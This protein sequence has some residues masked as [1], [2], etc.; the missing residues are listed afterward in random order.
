MGSQV[1]IEALPHEV[2]LSEKRLGRLDGLVRRYVDSGKLPGAS[3][4]VVRNSLVAHVFNYGM[5]DVANGVAMS[6][7]TIVRLYSMTKPITSVAAMM[8]HEEGAFDLLDP[9]SNFIPSFADTRVWAGGNRQEPVT[10][11][12][13][14]PMRIWNLLS[15]TSGLTYGF[16]LDH[17][18]DA[19]YRRAG[20]GLSAPEG[21]DLA[22]ACDFFAGLPLLFEPGTEWNYSVSTD[23]LGRV[24][25]VASG[26]SLD[27]FFEERIFQP[28]GMVDTG[29]FVKTDRYETLASL[30]VPEP[31]TGLARLLPVPRDRETK[32]PAL[33]SGGG[34]LYGTAADYVRFT[35]MLL[36]GGEL[37][38]N[39]VLG[40]KTLQ[41]MT[42]NHL[43]GNAELTDIGRRSLPDLIQP[44]TGFGLGFA[45]VTDPVRAKVPGSA[46]TFFWGGA[47]STF[48]F[49]D[50]VERI[51]LVF[52][53][54]LLPSSTYPLRR[55]LRQLVM[56]SVVD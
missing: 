40:R 18:V 46:G 1:E 22:H 45:V 34:G 13:H 25:E 16:A 8:L 5:R 33:L 35:K 3:V 44:G 17:P 43:P 20:F 21:T 39:R 23:V 10:A 2:G 4:A 29:F 52:L 48:F 53:T 30:Y 38:N 14:E 41:L 50:P 15:H 9:V 27:A 47:A 36:Q 6:P 28:L 31:G 11:P 26:M 32:A 56:Q 42:S 19:M 55:Q 51:T 7:D 54:Q 24:V 37:E 12:L 49:V